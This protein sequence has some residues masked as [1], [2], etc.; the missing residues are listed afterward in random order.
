M[1][2][3]DD[4]MIISN[5]LTVSNRKSIPFQI[6]SL[7]CTKYAKHKYL[8]VIKETHTKK[9]TLKIISNN[10]VHRIENN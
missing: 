2:I 4:L 10:I 1:M 8:S 5:L 9:C 7:K 6:K 3:I